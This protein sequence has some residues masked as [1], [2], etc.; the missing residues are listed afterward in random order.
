MAMEDEFNRI[1]EELKSL[2]PRPLSRGALARIGETLTDK[3]RERDRIVAFPG[4]F[5]WRWIGTVAAAAAAALL[6]VLGAVMALIPGKKGL[7]PP[8]AGMENHAEGLER[9]GTIACGT[10]L[11]GQRNEGPVLVGVSPK[12]PVRCVRYKFE[13]R[14][15]WY[16]K[17]R[18]AVF[19]ASVP[20]EEVKLVSLTMD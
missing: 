7:P 18:G 9:P 1:E 8:V 6:L 4:W 13:D 16:D 20:R 11:V 3:P 5:A 12:V 19:S 17:E 15:R 2:R 10:V 14:V